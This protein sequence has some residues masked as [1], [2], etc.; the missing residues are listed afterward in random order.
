MNTNPILLLQVLIL[1]VGATYSS[2]D[3]KVSAHDPQS[4]LPYSYSIT[5]LDTV[6]TPSNIYQYPTIPYVPTS[7]QEDNSD[8]DL[9]VV[10]AVPGYPALAR[11]NPYLGLGYGGYPHAGYFGY[12]NHGY[13]ALPGYGYTGFGG[14]GHPL[15]HGHPF[16]GYYGPGPLP[17]DGAG[18]D[19][20]EN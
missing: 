13:G 8:E 6:P 19:N 17:V 7:E 3:V 15:Y 12:P 10:P 9:P 11:Y 1:L 14:Y 2:T 4:G 16:P 5:T 18:V 20:E